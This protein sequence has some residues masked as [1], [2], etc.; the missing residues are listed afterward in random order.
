MNLYDIAKQTCHECGLPWIDPRTGTVHQPPKTGKRLTPMPKRMRTKPCP[1]HD[2]H[3]EAAR[4]GMLAVFSQ[5]ALMLK[6]RKRKPELIEE[7][8]VI[9]L[10]RI[11]SDGKGILK[12]W[13][14]DNT[15][16]QWRKVRA[17]E[18]TIYM[19]RVPDWRMNVY[20]ANIGYQCDTFAGVQPLGTRCRDFGGTYEDVK[21]LIKRLETLSDGWLSMFKRKL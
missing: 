3:I 1:E 17:A 9:S 7:G 2:S 18:V 16:D 6:P 13:G 12:L 4:T 5:H 19:G 15:D 10:R 20:L 21:P 8:T 11:E 14:V